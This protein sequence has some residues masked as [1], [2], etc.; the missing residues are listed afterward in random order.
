MGSKQSFPI[1]T[2]KKSEPATCE[3]NHNKKLLK[4]KRKIKCNEL[5]L[6]GKED[7]IKFNDTKKKRFQSANTTPSSIATSTTSTTSTTCRLFTNILS[8]KSLQQSERGSYLAAFF[9]LFDDDFIQD[10]LWLDRC[11]TLC[12]KYLIAMVYVYF[13]RAK[14]LR[15]EFT[16]LHFFLALYIAHEIEEDN[17]NLKMEI[18]P[19][20]LGSECWRSRIKEFLVKRNLFLERMKFRAVVSSRTCDEVFELFPTHPVWQRERNINHGGANR[21]YDE[22]CGTGEDGDDVEVFSPSKN[23]MKCKICLNAGHGGGGAKETQLDSDNNM[24]FQNGKMVSKNTFV[25]D[26]SPGS[27]DLLFGKLEMLNSEE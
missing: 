1:R 13:R 20:A 5:S 23:Q 15:K 25:R 9:R 17:E 7:N 3:T 27:D 4:R 18:Y 8:I 22:L 2:D 24:Y 21:F 14:L 6:A 12:D 16:R 10:F 26:H 11:Y 19:W